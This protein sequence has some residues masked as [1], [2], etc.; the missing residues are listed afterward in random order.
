MYY[1]IYTTVH[2]V[3]YSIFHVNNVH[4]NHHRIFKKNMGP[5]ICDIAFGTKHDV[6]H[7]IENTDHYLPNIAGAFVVVYMLQRLYR[8]NPA[9]ETVFYRTGQSLYGLA[10][11]II[12]ISTAVLY[13]QDQEK[14]FL[15]EYKC[16]EMKPTVCK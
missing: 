1:L 10:L 15:K 5:D 9:W 14:L 6:E 11:L 8:E 3:N 13:Y 16:Q 4:E 7:S 2:N 12:G